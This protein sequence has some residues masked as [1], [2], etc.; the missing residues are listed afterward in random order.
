VV[1]GDVRPTTPDRVSSAK[2]IRDQ[3]VVVSADIY[4]DGHDELAARL[5]WRPAGSDGWWAAPMTPLGNDR[6]AG[7]WVPTELGAHEFAIQGWVDAWAT[8][9]QRVRTKLEAGVGVS[10][11]LED[12]TLLLEGIRVGPVDHAFAAEIAALR[13]GDP[14]PALAAEVGPLPA[15]TITTTSTQRV[16]VDRPLAAVGAW[17][18]L[19]PR[20]YGGLAGTAKRMA[21]VAAMGFDVVYLPPI[22]PIGMT[23]RKGPGN[24]VGAGPDGIGSPWAI[25]SPAGG[26]DAVHPELGTLDDFDDLVAEAARLDMEVALDYALQC[27]PDHPWVHEHPEWFQRRAD[28]SIRFAENPPKKYEDIFPLD[29]MAPDDEDRQ[30]LWAACRDVL[31]HWIAHGVRVFR[32]DNPHTKPFAFW[33]WLLADVRSRHPDVVWLSEAFTR[34]R[35]MERLAEIG[36]SQGYTYFTWR[37]TRDELAAYADELAH[38]RAADYFRPNLWT[39]THDIL[40]GPL[41]CGGPG[42]F[43]QRAVLAATIGP[44]WGVYSGYELIENEPASEDN[45]EYAHSEK[46]ELPSRDWDDPRSIAPFLTLLN[47]IRRRHPA[48]TDL[49]SLR[50]HGASDPSV[51]AFSKQVG[52]DT[53]LVVVNVDSHAPHESTLHLDLGALGFPWEAVLSAHDEISGETFVWHGPEP[54]VRLT[55]AE[56][57]HVIHLRVHQP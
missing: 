55:P 43:K 24:I 39:N 50:I 1:I 2:A 40:S 13:A 53:V 4:A 46:Y 37:N 29:L 49:R 51:L 16:W 5:W 33:Q 44:S 52:A 38:G 8:W 11:E 22:H 57:A 34:P 9:T 10:D 42:A 7:S 23:A 20:S 56:P 15:G 17:Y 54:Y 27:S 26:H 21:A 32:V 3:A 45:D 19:F 14:L 31:E 25:G 28:G 41:R 36:F 47:D 6:W 48:L 12:G 18:E 30:A 35:V